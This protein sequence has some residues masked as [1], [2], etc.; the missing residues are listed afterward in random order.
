LP[1]AHFFQQPAAEEALAM[2]EQIRRHVKECCDRPENAF[3]PFF[4]SEHLA[5]VS[6]YAA[7]LCICLD[8]DNEIVAAAS[9]L[10]DISAVLD[11]NTLA[12]HHTKSAEY[13]ET[14][15]LQSDFPESKRTRVKQCIA[16]H[17]RPLAMDAGAI[18]DICIS[19]ADAIAQIVNP[20][21]WL[22]Y[23]FKVRS[24]SYDTGKEWYAGKI[25]SN[26]DLL[27]KPA[28]DLVEEKYNLVKEAL[29]LH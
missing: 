13:A 19:N 1:A 3:S 2:T 11:F 5:V 8:G 23:V 27:I 22:Y 24:M 10:H 14:Y 7:A 29:R 6:E 12:T 16:N 4:F 9:W 26:W 17:T 20:S 25:A 21:Y 15:L 18:E 28:K